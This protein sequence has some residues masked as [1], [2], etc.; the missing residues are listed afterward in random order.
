MNSNLF[1][2]TMH[3]L[4]KPRFPMGLCFFIAMTIAG[5]SCGSRRGG[6]VA[7]ADGGGGGSGDAQ[8][9]GAMAAGDAGDAQAYS[10][11][12][13]IFVTSGTYGGDLVAPHGLIA[14]D[15]ECTRLGR[16]IDKPGLDTTTWVA[17]LSTS[18]GAAFDRVRDSSTGWY[19]VDESTLVFANREQMRTHPSAVINMTETS[20][21]LDTDGSVGVWT[22]TRED[23]VAATNNCTNWTD[24]TTGVSGMAAAI[25]AEMATTN[26][27]WTRATA[28]D[29]LQV[30]SLPSHLY[31]IQN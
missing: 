17:W 21:S 6:Y 23:L 4:S 1:L 15:A 5:A 3:D 29:G 25:V 28:N 9:D 8:T 18:N 7:P 31:C 20:S 14:A 26:G 2:T 13:Y 27:L 19:L 10:G 24:G 30:C 11:K 16:M 22:G 12:R